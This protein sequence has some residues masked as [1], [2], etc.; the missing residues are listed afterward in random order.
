MNNCLRDVGG[1]GGFGIASDP[2]DRSAKASPMGDSAIP[3]AA[4]AALAWANR[5]P[6]PTL[7]EVIKSITD[8]CDCRVSFE[9]GFT[10]NAVP[11][12]AWYVFSGEHGRADIYD[13]DSLQAFRQLLR[14]TINSIS[15]AFDAGSVI[16]ICDITRSLTQ[17]TSRL[18]PAANITVL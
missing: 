12:V 6:P 14:R 4:P 13:H 9:L 11:I 8:V 16:S 2:S 3:S 17:Q 10:A 18:T 7:G 5:G 15:T 1:F